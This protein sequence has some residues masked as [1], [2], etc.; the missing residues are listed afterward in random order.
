[1]GQRGHRTAIR[2]IVVRSNSAKRAVLSTFEAQILWMRLV[3]LDA[4][5]PVYTSAL[6]CNQEHGLGAQDLPHLGRQADRIPPQQ[7]S[8]RDAHVCASINSGTPA[9]SRAALAWAR[10]ARQW[11]KRT[12]HTRFSTF[13]SRCQ[14]HQQ[15]LVFLCRPSLQILQATLATQPH[16][17]PATEAPALA[18]HPQT[19]GR[20]K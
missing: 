17:S 8:N 3:V 13:Q 9:K 18:C 5:W 1:M 6:L 15:A 14:L 11:Y 10:C 12:H 4:F 2:D 7:I 20:Q 19:L 16:H